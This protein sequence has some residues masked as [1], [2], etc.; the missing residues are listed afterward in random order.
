[1]LTICQYEL[2]KLEKTD[3]VGPSCA[4]TIELCSHTEELTENVLDKFFP[5]DKEINL[6]F[7]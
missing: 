6:D 5:N 1:V 2:Y 3:E 4:S 7:S